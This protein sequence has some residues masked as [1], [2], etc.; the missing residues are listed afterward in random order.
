M[1][2]ANSSTPTPNG[3]SPRRR[4]RLASA[5]VLALSLV[6]GL[7]AL[8]AQGSKD[9]ADDEDA[10]DALAAQ[11]S[12][13][14]RQAFAK[15]AKDGAGG[16]CTFEPGT[17]MAYDVVTHTHVEIDFGQMA[18]DAQ[19]A[20]A[21]QQGAQMQVARDEAKIH[22][23]ERSWH[24]DLVALATED[25]GATVLAAR[26]QDRGM[27]VSV[28]E[29]EPESAAPEASANIDDTFL[30]RLDS[31][32]S[33][34]EFG[35]RTEGD[36]DATRQQ[37]LMAAGLA[38]WAP[39][40]TAEESTYTGVSFDATGRYE[41][42]YAFETDGTLTGEVHSF[43]QNPGA[44]SVRSSFAPVAMTVV[45]STIEA[46]LQPG[47]WF[48]R[49]VNARDLELRFG[50]EPFGAHLRSTKAERA[51][52]EGFAPTVELDDGGWSW[53]LVPAEAPDQSQR[54]DPDL[55]GR[56][57]DDV[58]A[59]F[60]DMLEGG[61][62]VGSYG[63]LLRDWL[64]A[65]PEQ[66]PA[67]LA[68]LE[69]GSFE[70]QSHARAGIFFALGS[71]NTEAAKD[72]LTALL[73][74]SSV[75]NQIGAAHALSMVDSPRT[76]MLAL[77]AEGSRDEALH[78]MER[79]TMGL[80]LGAVAQHAELTDPEAAAEARGIIGGWLDA[81]ADDEQIQVA[82]A[83]A[84]NAG[85]DELGAAVGRYLDHEDTKVRTTA[86][87]AMRQ[88]SPEEAFPRLE[89]A[90]GDEQRVVRQTALE[91]AAAVA[92]TQG[93]APS[94]ALVELAAGSLA[95][96]AH[97][98]E[99]HAAMALLGEAAK[100]GD[101]DA[102]GLLDDELRSQLDGEAIDAKAI[103]AIGRNMPGRWRANN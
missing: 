97:Q 8:D 19:D 7:T 101:A 77:L 60:R 21:Q 71:A 27:K 96:D 100:R 43:G 36:L 73:R 87:K 42:A 28:G 61:E 25:D 14:K 99:R 6:G 69:D 26:I 48:E 30:I 84:G 1:T 31:R 29:D 16:L 45:D 63:G 54:F 86:T 57:L 34:R 32:C 23:V 49:L 67:V 33:I 88:M 24:L 52:F 59:N 56:E 85:H 41:A 70:G 82:L 3:T 46:Q 74:E 75:A 95:P 39:R 55:V 53:G 37:Q 72:G 81:P 17:Q 5:G 93:T 80:A 13:A 103:A 4:W 64:R 44:A 65:N 15:L 12:A 20:M 79:G 50:G 35:W 98:A 102:R 83:A 11:R 22:D 94:E 62:G 89:A 92:R 2:A 40:S 10:A 91:T 76:E 47:Q 18:A 90:M 68:L 58:L 78:P 9:A 51:D 38:F 66:T